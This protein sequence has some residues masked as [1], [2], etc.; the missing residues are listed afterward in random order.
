MWFYLK[1]LSYFIVFFVL[2]VLGVVLLRTIISN[3]WHQKF[4]AREIG[5]LKSRKTKKGKFN[6]PDNT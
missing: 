2:L 6:T 5:F 1:T 3:F 4:L